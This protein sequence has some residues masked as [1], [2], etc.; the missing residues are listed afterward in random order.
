VIGPSTPSRYTEAVIWRYR[1]TVVLLVVLAALPAAG[2]LC[3]MTCLSASD[4]MAS[5]HGSEQRCDDE[6]PVSVPQVTA[7]SQHDC[8][9][10]DPALVKMATTPAQRADVVIAAPAATNETVYSP[11]TL[12][13]SLTR[14]F[15][16]T[17]QLDTAPPTT[18]P[19]VLRV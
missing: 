5:H 2:A 11:S 10:H 3:A 9:N 19:L 1:I 7:G 6:A 12:L 13:V 16:Y 8:G 4:S 18:T 15:A 14:F 17:P